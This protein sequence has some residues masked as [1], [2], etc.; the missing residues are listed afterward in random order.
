MAQVFLPFESEMYASSQDPPERAGAPIC[1]LR[2]FPYSPLHTLRWAV[3]AFSS[4]FTQRAADVNAYLGNKE[5]VEKHKATSPALQLP[6]LEMLRNALVTH[7][8]FRWGRGQLLL[9]GARG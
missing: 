1:T 5:F 3:E 6:V 2:N 8:P 4:L 9:E 7:R